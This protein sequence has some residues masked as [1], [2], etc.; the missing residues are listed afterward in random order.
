M[1]NAPLYYPAASLSQPF[2]PGAFRMGS[3]NKVLLHSTETQSWPAYGGAGG[4]PTLTYN[5][6][7]HEWR[8]HIP[9]TARATALM[10]AGDYQTNRANVVQIEIVG[11]ADPDTARKYGHAITAVDDA[12][13]KDL[14]EFVAWMHAHYG[15][16]I[17]STTIWKPYPASYG[18]NNGVRLSTAQFDAYRGV[19]GHQHAPGNYHGDPGGLNVAKIIT[20]AQAAA[21]Q[22]ATANAAGTFKVAA[23]PKKGHTYRSPNTV[24]VRWINSRRK[25]GAFSR[26]VWFVQHWLNLAGYPYGTATGYWDAKT[27]QLYDRFRQAH[28]FHGADATGAVGPTSLNQLRAKAHATKKVS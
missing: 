3:V 15:V 7:T 26:H 27:E 18:T 10:N 24:S 4:N 1:A 11:Y 28:G 8:Q 12:A 23:G 25:S 6:W 16:R 2:D 14:G 5:P 9:L 21:G 17:D 19:L 22:A 13:L 20:Y